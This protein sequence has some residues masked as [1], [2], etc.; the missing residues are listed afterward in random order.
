MNLC[1]L[2]FSSLGVSPANEEVVF[3]FCISLLD[4]GNGEGDGELVV[5]QA[6]QFA[7]LVLVRD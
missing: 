7:G 6:L 5:A 3:V 4:R 2:V 1:S